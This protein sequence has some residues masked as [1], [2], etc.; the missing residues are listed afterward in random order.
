MTKIILHDYWRST[1][2]YRVRLVL[3][4][5]NIDFELRSVD[6]LSGEHKQDLYMDQNPMG[7]VPTLSICDLHL[8][9]SL[10]IIDFLDATYPDPPM[11]SDDPI[12][13]AQTLAQALNIAA[14]I[15]PIN[16]MAIGNY[17]KEHF[18]ADQ[19]GVVKW[20][21]HWMKRG[22]DALEEQAPNSGLF[23]G[24]APNLADVCL[25]PQ[26]YNARRFDMDLGDYPK[27]KRIDSDCAKLEAFKI[28]TPV[29]AKEQ[30]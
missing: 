11:V 16:N 24:N 13:R 10:A 25:I 2:S 17:L 4:L 12:E 20:M 9:Q 23:G 3:N 14:D 22:F 29:L 26:L 6:L 30:G 19:D 7:L 5:K 21:H 15:H 28:S 1:A 27:L 8:T 18:D